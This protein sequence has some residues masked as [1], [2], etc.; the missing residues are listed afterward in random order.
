MPG[1][2]RSG[3][4][5]VVARCCILPSGNC[6]RPLYNSS[7]RP[8]D[9]SQEHALSSLHPDRLKAELAD[10]YTIIRELGRGG[11]ATVYLAR[12]I[13]HE[14]QVAIKV[15][16]PD[17]ASVLGPERFAR[18]IN[19][20]SGL[21]HP[22]IL[23]IFDS[24]AA[25]GTLYYTMPFV[26]GK[27]LRARLDREH[28]L[29]VHEALRIAG[30]VA[31][32][33]D[34]AHRKGI[35]HRDIKPE[36]IL[37]DK[38]GQ[39]I[40]ADF[41]IARAI[42]TAGDERLTRTGLTLGTPAYM[43]P[44]QATAERDID[45]RSDIYALGCVLY[46]ML[47]GT[48]PFSGPNAQAVTVRHLIDEVPSLV[49]IRRTVPQHVEQSIQI[50]M[51]KSP[52]DRFATGEE[53]AKA[54][55]D[56][57]GASL[58]N[59][60]ASLPVQGDRRQSRRTRPSNARLAALVLV[61]VL[62]I[63]V[64]VAAWR[65][66]MEPVRVSGA[67]V[68]GLDRVAVMYFEDR[69]GN[70][71]FLADGFTES[72]IQ[73]LSRIEGIEVLSANAVAPF[74]SA[75]PD[76]VLKKL[77][78]GL[79]LTGGLE[80]KD[81]SLLVSLRL[82]SGDPNDAK[83]EPVTFLVPSADLLAARNQVTQRATHLLLP[84]LGQNLKLA[85]SRLKTRSADA[86]G[87]VQR[88]AYERKSA[89]AQL[90]AGDRDG[91]QL[92]LALADS[93]LRAAEQ[94]DPSWAEPTAQR[95]RIAA[96]RARRTDRGTM[97][98]RW[99]EGVALADS[100]LAVDTAHSGAYEVRGTLRYQLSNLESNP[101]AAQRLFSEAEKDL[102]AAT[103]FDPQNAPAWFVLSLVH[104]AQSDYVQSALAAQSAYNADKY[105]ERA[106]QILWQLF[107]TSYSMEQHATAKKYCDEGAK[108]FPEN[109][110]FVECQ[111][112]TMTTSADSADPARAR[113]LIA[114]LQRVK[115]PA[116]WEFSRRESQMLLAAVMV[117][118]ATRVP[119]YR[120]SASALLVAARGNP[121][122]DPH[123]T[124]LTREAFVRALMGDN[125]TAI[126]LLQRY[127]LEN[128]AARQEFG[129]ENDW[130]WRGLQDDPRFARLTGS[131]GS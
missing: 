113:R 36:N 125:D 30:D 60:T 38:S 64:G 109:P 56:A 111:L 94:A 71:A 23:G 18:E 89:L 108:R 69:G 59:Y 106:P 37:L 26:E 92:R 118:S 42:D 83:Q 70:M 84:R 98:R 19:L 85:E 1:S 47:A 119:A 100:A 76:T 81:D 123:R 126:E 95:A 90:N 3:V 99:E 91:S 93:L 35:V 114:D 39:V 107:A 75:A 45:G 14:R 130:W 22:N 67:A 41:G 72:V 97:T 33:L 58:S 52:A 10:R 40:V 28:Q 12:D 25:A 128:P 80:A 120:D 86:W 105:L 6:G 48:P 7:A 24:G 78:T 104:A 122:V 27:S 110:Q 121:T 21:K 65:M 79:V 57:S 20:A 88:A 82:V 55:Q 116:D 103:R 4:R 43:S 44:E 115:P 77:Q 32:A 13:A 112:W 2:R 46:E 66:G 127:L 5:Q 68:R 61:P 54:L 8:N 31:S 124:L 17:L 49:T 16:L 9:P 34:L 11:M 63:A 129:R 117:R 96:D 62:L 15:L 50:A 51:A 101:A 131:G 74:R 102:S 53:F 73:E 29:P 87:L